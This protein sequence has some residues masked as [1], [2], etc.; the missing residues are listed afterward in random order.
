MTTNFITPPD[1]VDD[2]N[3]NILL[4]DVSPDDVE[5]LAFLCAG[6]NEAFNVYLFNF[7]MPDQSWLTKVAEFADAIVV[8]T[9]ETAL[10]PLK[11][12]LAMLPK[13]YYY[14]PKNF[15]N[16]DQKHSTVLEYFINRANERKSQTSSTL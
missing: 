14:G 7:E 16:N 6:H 5:T 8:N 12:V 10:S 4:I 9:N 13:S 2:P 3:H 1:I 15:A 11:D